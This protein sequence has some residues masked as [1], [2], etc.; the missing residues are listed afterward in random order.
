MASTTY[1]GLIDYKSKKTLYAVL[2]ESETNNISLSVYK[3]WDGT[4]E[5]SQDN[6]NWTTVT[7]SYTQA[8]PFISTTGKIYARGL[9]NTT[10]CGDIGVS[11]GRWRFYNG[12]NISISGNINCLLDWQKVKNKENINMASAAFYNMFASD[13]KIKD[14]SN[15]IL[16]ATILT[17]NCYRSMFNNCDNLINCPALPATTLAYNCYRAMFDSCDN[18]ETLPTLPATNLIYGCYNSMFGA[19]SKI[20]L[21]ETQTGDY[22][23]PYRIPTT[24]TGTTANSALNDMFR[25]TG[26]TFKGTPSINTTYYT[27]NEIVE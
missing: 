7:E 5:L 9:N 10:I 20:K 18:L 25:Y 13:Q 22:Q 19:N 3:G 27:S 24:G 21:S 2:F 17:D 8:N 6:I 12:T 14:I 15:L 4:L 26:G 11:G 23:T 16:P 1:Y